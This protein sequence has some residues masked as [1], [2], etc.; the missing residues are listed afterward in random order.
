MG[1]KLAK[2]IFLLFVVLVLAPWPVAY[3]YDDMAS[4]TGGG[5]IQVQVADPSV[6]PTCT[7]FRGAVGSVTPGDLF[8]VDATDDAGDIRVTLHLSNSDELISW[9]RFLVV[10]VGVYV[11]DNGGEWARAPMTDGELTPETRI[12]LQDAEA[13]FVL[14]GY[15]R[16]KVALDGGSFNARSVNVG[17]GSAAPQFSLAVNQL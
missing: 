7:A 3:A 12:T 5:A 8:Y 11:E 2:L 17:G 14:P 15:A 9:Y 6:S 16:Y 10:K 1:R 13:G 4:L